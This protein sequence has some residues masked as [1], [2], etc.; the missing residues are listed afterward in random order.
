MNHNLPSSNQ[1]RIRVLFL[2]Y[3][4]AGYNL[5]CFKKFT[6]LYS[7]EVHVVRK[8]HDPHAPFDFTD[9]D[10][11]HFYLSTDYTS[12]QLVELAEEINPSFIFC[13]GWNEKKYL[14][15]CRHFYGKI[16]TVLG[17]DNSWE[18]TLKQHI[19]SAMAPV[20]LKRYFSHVWLPGEPQKKYALKIGFKPYQIFTGFYAANVEWYRNFYLQFRDEKKEKFPHV[21]LYVGRYLQLKGVQEMWDA[22]IEFQ[23]QTNSDWEMWCIGKGDLNFP[24]HPK[25]KDFGFVQPD[26][27]HKFIEKAGVLIL[28][29]RKDH[30]GMT[31]HEFGAAGF[32]L[33]CSDKTYA[34]TAFL[35]DGYNGYVHKAS[36]KN[37][38]I[39]ALKRLVN[40]PDQTRFEMGDRSAELAAKITDATWAETAWTIAQL[41]VIK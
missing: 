19:W 18:G 15:T 12:L 9:H 37:S 32:P 35:K 22:F 14:H 13:S 29:S 38:I 26:R 40:T 16:S 36:D 10:N 11:I 8:P 33:I 25:I 4:L 7:A 24:V 17:L 27:M 23:S 39:D 6:E 20:Y 41:K 1:N 28:S 30:W 31:V 34:I 2:Y 21:I 5:A 3:E